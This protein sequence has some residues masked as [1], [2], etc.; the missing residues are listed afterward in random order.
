MSEYILCKD[1]H[2]T[3]VINC[4]FTW[5]TFW[6]ILATKYIY[7]LIETFYL[8]SCLQ[9]RLQAADS[10]AHNKACVFVNNNLLFT[11]HT[12]KIVFD[13]E[14][15]V[16]PFNISSCWCHNETQFK[17]ITCWISDRVRLK[18]GGYFSCDFYIM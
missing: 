14:V 17:A 18:A 5:C 3:L 7:L 11:W 6:F 2:E 13:C 10:T 4:L 1:A 12:F 8:K 9:L 15:Y 16:L